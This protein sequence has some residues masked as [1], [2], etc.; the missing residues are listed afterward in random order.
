MVNPQ[1]IADM[2]NESKTQS[3]LKSVSRKGMI[4]SRIVRGFAFFVIT[5]C[6]LISVVASILAIWDFTKTDVLLRTIAT[7]CVVGGGVTIFAM[8]NYAF[9]PPRQ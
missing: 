9:G 6:I 1:E 7:C 3:I 5:L 8:V 2:T 4:N